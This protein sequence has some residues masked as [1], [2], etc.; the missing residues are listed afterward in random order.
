MKTH[1]SLWGFLFLPCLAF[2]DDLPGAAK[3]IAEIRQAAGKPSAEPATGWAKDRMDFVTAL[4]GLP[5]TE[6]GTRW[7]DLVGQWEQQPRPTR[8]SP[9]EMAGQN[10]DSLIQIIP[11]P[12]AWD[13]IQAA[14]DK[15]PL[16]DPLTDALMA[17]FAATLVNDEAAKWQAFAAIQE[18]VAN[19]K[20]DS[21]VIG[22]VRRM[23][24][25]E[26]DNW[27]TNS[28]TQLAEALVQMSD[29]PKHILE[30]LNVQLAARSK[31]AGHS[32]DVP[33]LVTLAGE[34][35]A[36]TF[37]K[38]ALTQPVE[39]EVS[40]RST[41][42]LA[43]DLALAGMARMTVPQWSL[44]NG[45]DESSIALYAALAKKFPERNE[46][47]YEQRSAAGFY[48]LGLIAAGR[49]AEAS[50]FARKSPNPE[51]LD[52]PYGGLEIMRSTG[53]GGE[54]YDF[55]FKLLETNPDLPF[56]SN[57]L[58]AAAEQRQ[59]A[60]AVELAQQALARPQLTG[61]QRLRVIQQLARAY[62]AHGETA[63]GV[64]QLRERLKWL[65]AAKPLN[66]SDILELGL[67]LVA[68]GELLP[69][70]A[71][72]KE[73]LQVATEAADRLPPRSTLNELFKVLLKAGR[74]TDILALIERDLKSQ[75]REQNEFSRSQMASELTDLAGVYDAMGRPADVLIL[76]AEAPWWGAGDLSKVLGE[77]DFR[78]ELLGLIAAR[79]L[80]AGGDK[81]AA[82]RV[83]EATLRVG[84]SKDA[85]Y[86]LLI[87]LMGDAAIPFLDELALANR[88]QERPL[89]WK[90]VLQWRAKQ[91]DAA[92]KTI[93]EAIAIDPSD[94]EMGPGDR[95]RAYAVLADIL[96]SRGNMEEAKLYRGAVAAIRLSEEADRYQR[97][98]LLSQAVAK[99]EEAL[100]LFADAYCIQSRLAIQFMKLGEVK[101]AEAHYLKAYELMPDSFGRVE[102]HCF[103][104]E[105]AFAGEM[106]ET[107]AEKTF[108][109]LIADNPSKPQL[110][111]L[112]GYLRYEQERYPEALKHF[113]KAVELDPDYL[114]AWKKILSVGSDMAIPQAVRDEAMLA[115]LR[116]NPEAASSDLSQVANLKA[117]WTLLAELQT[118]LPPAPTKGSLLPLTASVPPP[119]ANPHHF[120]GDF[121]DS[122]EPL[123]PTQLLTRH[124][125]LRQVSQMLTQFKQMQ[126]E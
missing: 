88:F 116:L 31:E 119:E 3:V 86:A 123:E 38:K 15:H 67:E 8:Y 10:F 44:V 70:P 100:L 93:R 121:G 59:T 78:G 91:F 34:E 73:G 43:R 27:L 63:K 99:Y 95:M 114:N 94:G 80:A 33:D 75:L 84:P 61:A 41:Q 65:M 62:L 46:S 122:D 24:G 77:M 76:L 74:S 4:P 110:H 19:R 106:A 103:G 69:D 14:T 125:I 58:D 25:A 55:L 11:P 85:A 26:A 113:R 102:S 72:T 28:V 56:W 42:K 54:V 57:F 39:L 20:P 45:I 5:P 53:R 51:E 112:L 17:L 16:K 111:Y 82:Q 66:D 1:H 108:T 29:D 13:S 81:E 89:I 50:E 52:L 47:N 60:A 64:A 49:T 96:E 7:I 40:G 87:E 21:A 92:E 18:K 9:A 71:L 36:L 32:L 30:A 35:P 12:A 97:A 101:K 126:P 79:A 37:L 107:L 48:L 90:A 109:R 6:A 23:M 118:K 83:L 98:G 22:M 117:A 105:R 68:L 120:M 2:A 104:C 115:I 124:A